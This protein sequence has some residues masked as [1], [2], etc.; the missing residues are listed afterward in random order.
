MSPSSNI[1]SDYKPYS[2]PDKVRIADGTFSSVSGKGLIH[3]TPSL[4]LTSVLHVPRFSHTLLSLSR[5]TRDLNCSVTFFSF[6]LCFSGS[7]HEEDD[8]QW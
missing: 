4:P 1:F 7:Y 6:S 2:G 3:A 5:I 8:W